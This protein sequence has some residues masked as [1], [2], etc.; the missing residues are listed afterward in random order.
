MSEEKH[1]RASRCS[2][3]LNP[4]SEMAV[5]TDAF[6]SLRNKRRW[7]VWRSEARGRTG[8]PTKI[9]YCARQPGCRADATDPTT[10]AKRAE[11]EDAARHFPNGAGG[12]V[13]I[14]LGDL[15]TDRY[16]S[17]LDLDGSVTDG[18]VSDWAA[19]LLDVVPSYAEVS[20]SS[21]GIKVFFYLPAAAVRP[22]L[23]RLN[24][25]GWGLK[26]GIP[27]L[28][29][30]AHGPGVELYCAAR[31]FTV[32]GRHWGRSPA[33]IALLDPTAI[34]ALVSLIPPPASAGNHGS[35]GGH[36][37]SRSAKAFRE[38]IRLKRQGCTLDE[39]R[40]ALSNHA[41]P[42]IAAW[43]REKGLPNNERE[44]QRL[45][46]RTGKTAP[47]DIP[48]IRVVAG[49]RHLAA[50]AG[51]A[52]LARA[53]AEFHHR[54]QTLVRVGLT[55]AKTA[56]GDDI[57]LPGIAPIT[58]PRL[59]RALGF[60][61]RWERYD[62][63]AKGWLRTDPPALIGE[64]IL[65]MADEWPFPPLAGLIACPSLRPDGSLLTEAGYDSA[66]GLYLADSLALPAIPEHPSR[67]DAVRA[68]RLF[69]DLLAEFPFSDDASRSV[70]LSLLI[71]PVVRAAVG[72]VVPA[73]GVDSPAPG[74]GKSYLTNLASEL[75]TGRPCAVVAA[76][77]KPEETDK[78]LN[79]VLLSGRTLISLD[80][81]RGT[82]A[83]ALLCQA[84]E[85]PMLDLRPLGTSTMTAIANTATIVLN[86][87]NLTIAEDLVR[88][89]L[90]CR[91]DADSET[92]EE[93][94]FQG[95]PIACVRRSR[96]AYVAAALTIVRAYAV[97][98]MPDGLA[99][100]PSF[101]NWSNK[102]RSALVWLGQADPAETMTAARL[103]D[104]VRQER[105]EI[106]QALAD[107]LGGKGMRTGEIIAEADKQSSSEA[108]AR[109]E[110][111]AALQRIAPGP[112]DGINA[113][114][115]GWWLRN[116]V[117]V[118]AGGWKLMVDHG[119]KARPRWQMRASQ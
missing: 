118:I 106:F 105:A 9:P 55:P 43:M 112:R 16:L 14:V 90:L 95:D 58:L 56:S 5:S 52:A 80:N 6:A 21:G 101:G 113:T 25:N 87:N 69:L 1:A 102:L 23:N 98:G 37:S 82:L 35:T 70:A 114:R 54:D 59:A 73:H 53:G 97:A 24:A 85:Q 99:P 117:D 45:W 18:L 96:P 83:S 33:R 7:L 3:Q 67:D 79:G 30:A 17:G 72:P 104:P 22:L 65:A 108:Y 57:L 111:R 49:E 86:G 8:K 29:G 75:A 89:T 78:R 64:Q 77:R 119:D 19:D 47:G 63:R 93:R 36:D 44:L 71:T 110:L 41:D 20:P 2:Q 51:L 10:W 94:I 115:L 40:E 27:G 34:D 61:A 12:G 32:T 100:L 50:D 81:I 66:T 39:L 103:D 91:L 84:I 11:A 4:S 42:E 74:T 62:M 28:A 60:A 116:N 48:T 15:G 13:G 38:A 109:P 88:R 76:D 68:L 107:A 26:R 92:P 31:F 46:L